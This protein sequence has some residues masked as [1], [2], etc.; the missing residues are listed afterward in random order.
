METIARKKQTVKGVVVSDKMSK[1]RII[2]LAREY[3]HPLYAKK[4][5]RHTRLFVHD[6]KN[7]TKVGDTVIAVSTRPLS[8]NKAFRISK[9]VEK[10]SVA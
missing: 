5:E 10:G 1:T 2:E 8:K 3:P 7:E 6:E 9:V 4:T